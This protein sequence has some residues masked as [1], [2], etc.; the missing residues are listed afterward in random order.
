MFSESDGYERFMDR[1]SRELAPMLV[2][3][4]QVAGARRCSTSD[5]EPAR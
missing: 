1:W 5:P 2:A 3:F 4:A